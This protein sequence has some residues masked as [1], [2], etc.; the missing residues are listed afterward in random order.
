M[1]GVI[2][3]VGEQ[4]EALRRD[5]RRQ[6]GPPDP[7]RARRDDRPHRRRLA[8][9]FRSRRA[10]R[11]RISRR[12]Q[13]FGYNQRVYLED[14]LKTCSRPDG[15]HARPSGSKPKRGADASRLAEALEK[16]ASAPGLALP[17]DGFGLAARVL[18]VTIGFVFLAM[19][20]FYVTRLTAHRE[21]WLHGKI[22]WTPDRDRSL[23]ARR[24][25][26]AVRRTYRRRFSTQPRRE[27]ARGRDTLGT[28]RVRRSEV[29]RRPAAEPID[30]RRQFLFRE[31]GGHLSHPVRRARHG[32]E[33]ERPGPGRTNRRS[34]SPSTRSR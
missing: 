21:M 19:G 34:S 13:F 12:R 6:G 29:A 5:R 11:P 17:L 25:R 32:R 1:P 27:V 26:P 8:A 2:V 18:A 28:P 23:R 14:E 9:R 7:P 31:P 4:I 3:T 20:L 33:A 16:H 15:D 10:P 30:R 24:P 22:G